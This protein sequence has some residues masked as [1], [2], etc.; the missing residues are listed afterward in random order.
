MILHTGG[1]LAF[2]MPDQKS[3]LEIHLE[4]AVSLME[5][6]NRLEIPACRNFPDDGERD[7]GGFERSQL[8]RMVMRS[9]LFQLWM[10]VDLEV[11]R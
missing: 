7:H 3:T 6:V 2:F 10:A 11:R 9:A 8:L 1:Y 5:I 4:K